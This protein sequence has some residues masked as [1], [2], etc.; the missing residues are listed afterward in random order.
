[1]INNEVTIKEVVDEGLCTG[2]GTCSGTC[3]NSAINMVINSMGIYVPKLIDDKCNKCGVCFNSCPGKYFY[4]D[5]FNLEI[6]GKKPEN[7]LLGNFINCYLAHSTDH[8]IRYNFIVN[9]CS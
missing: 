1:M 2:C 7:I 9:L 6:F 4:F 5:N 3:P 8:E